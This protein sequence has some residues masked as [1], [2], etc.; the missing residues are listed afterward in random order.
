[1]PS[2][3]A[4]PRRHFIQATCFWLLLCLICAP[5]FAAA[6]I[7]VRPHISTGIAYDDNIFLE[8]SN[9]EHDVST[10]V[11]PGVD[12]N[13]TGQKAKLVISYN[14]TYSAYTRFPENNFW[15]HSAV[16]DGWADITSNVRLEV[17]DAFLRTEDPISETESTLRRGREP[18]STN[19]A[20]IGMINRLGANAVFELRYEHHVLKND[21][22]AV[23]DNSYQRPKASMTYWFSPNRYAV[24]LEGSYTTS[25]FDVSE[26]FEDLSARFRLTKRFGRKFDTY[27]EYTHEYTDFLDNG[28]DYE[29]Y[30]PLVGFSW[31]EQKNTRFAA[32]FGYFYR[33]NE[34]SDDNNG[35]VGALETL[36]SWSED[37]SVTVNGDVGYDRAAYGSQ[38][39]GFNPFYSVEGSISHAL[40]RRLIGSAFAGYR[41]N[42]Y[43]DEDPDRDD[44]ILRGGF[45]LAYQPLPWMTFRLDYLYQNVDSSVNTDDYTDNRGILSVTLAPRQAVKL[46]KQ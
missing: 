32:S 25:D 19:T 26:D 6:D 43:I 29:V 28:E 2:I 18:Y 36:Y 1:M 11:N 42:L 44:V 23:E 24:E 33:N 34:I 40:S 45:G 10:V 27:I 22:P 35:I 37:S 41:F 31:Q 20:G 21:D 5:R 17:K 8:A 14:P 13:L 15:S 7:T 3:L 16:A 9:K 46:F 38:N 39:L 4:T 30:S 12:L